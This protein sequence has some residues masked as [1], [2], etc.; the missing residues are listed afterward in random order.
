MPF[1]LKICLKT[2]GVGDLH[3]LRGEKKALMREKLF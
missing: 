2:Q 3:D 1:D